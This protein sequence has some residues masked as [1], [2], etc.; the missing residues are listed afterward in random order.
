[1]SRFSDSGEWERVLIQISR[2]QD[3][4]NQNGSYAVHAAVAGKNVWVLGSHQ[5]NHSTCRES[6][7]NL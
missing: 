1:M 6:L 3:I 4:P 5:N 7:N 2:I